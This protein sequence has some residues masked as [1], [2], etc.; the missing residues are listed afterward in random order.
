MI[1]AAQDVTNDADKK[2]RLRA[3]MR[4]NNSGSLY[5]F[6]KIKRPNLTAPKRG[7]KLFL[8]QFN[9]LP[10]KLICNKDKVFDKLVK[11][12]LGRSYF[13]RL[14]EWY[15]MIFISVLDRRLS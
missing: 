2:P 10:C 9:K 5:V 3:V 4:Q 8:S 14:L 6:L 13:S 7:N 11:E 15:I 1:L 12:V